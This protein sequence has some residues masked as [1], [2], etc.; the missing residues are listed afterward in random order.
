[1]KRFSIVNNG[2]NIDEVNNFIDIVIKKLEK[3]SADNNNYLMQLE[4]LKK[5]VAEANTTPKPVDNIDQK[6]AKALIA[7]QETTDKMK[8]LAK[9]EA[10]L[11]I[12]E[13]KEN[14][15]AIVHEALVNAAKTEQ[16]TELLKKNY[17]VY[18]KKIES[19]IKAQLEL[20]NDPKED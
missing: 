4:Q 9:E 15:N 19:L 3:L 5:Q 17:N 18:R 7:A 8:S 16:E 6:V 13:A 20:I 11:I 1:M 2:Y 14:A 10:E 12:K